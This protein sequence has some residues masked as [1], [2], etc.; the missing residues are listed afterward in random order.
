M[1]PRPN[2]LAARDAAFHMH[3]YT[4]ALKNEKE[5]GFVVT[6]GKGIYVYDE[7]GKEYLDGMAALWC[8]GLGFG[9]EPRL[10]QA[11]VKQMQELPFYHTFTQKVPAVTVELAEKLV[12]LAPVPMSKAYF[13]NSGSEANDTVVKMIWYMNN[14]LGRKEKKK[15]ISRTKAYHGVTVAAASLTGLP[16][17]HIDFDLPIAGILRTDCPHHYRFG[18]P[19]ESE[20]AFAT[21]CAE[22]LEK[23]VL[24]EGPETIAAM[25]AEPVMGAGGVIVPPK[26]YFAKIQAV[27]KKYDILLVADEVICG[28]GRT[29]NFWGT[30]TF[31]LQPDIMT[32]AKQLSA[33]VLPISAI[34]INQKVYEAL[35][36]NSAKNGVFGHGIT[37]SGH[38]V[39]AAVAL[40]TLKIYEERKIVDRVRD[41][42]PIFLRE[43]HRF[44]DHPLVGE[45]RGVG[46]VG[47]VELVKDKAT[48][49]SFDA[50]LA[51]G[52]NLVRIAHDHGLIIRAVGDSLAFCPPMIITEAEITDMFRRFEKALADTV[53]WLQ[54]DGH[55]QAA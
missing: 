36:D 12:K 24:A 50:S 18:N 38:P 30:E 39:C 53:S 40:E 48:R 41:L 54:R 2:S 15:I 32:M 10:T 55:L 28:F 35:R 44:Q 42:S 45:T 8:S 17:L 13:C 11:A 37:Y 33:G 16:G 7:D 21:R 51:V 29:G 3:G 31:G 5:G 22:N 6:R 26:T 9:E 27:L 46:L 43:L 25:F 1:S 47:A 23:L 14:A 34:L 19:G 52:P 49:Q 4:N 20:E